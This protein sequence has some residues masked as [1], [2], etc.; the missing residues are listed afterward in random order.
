[1][2]VRELIERYNAA[3]NAQD[4]DAIH[5]LHHPDIVFDNHTADERA[6]GAEAVRDHIAAI[7]QQ[8]PDAAVHDAIAPGRRRLRRL[9]VDGLDRLERMGRGRRLPAQ[10]RAD[11]AEGRVLVVASAARAAGLTSSWSTSGRL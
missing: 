9:R 4:L 2:N 11:C 6:E 8:Q 1:M 3:W 10:G 5:A 7:F